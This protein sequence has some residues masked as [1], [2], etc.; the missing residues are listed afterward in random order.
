MLLT[1][2]STTQDAT[3]LGYLLHKHPGKVQAF[4]V[5]GG[6]AQVFYPEA[7]AE[8]CTAVLLLDVDP[9]ALVRGRKGKW[10]GGG[11][12]G[13]TLDHYVNDR[14]YAASSML[15]VAMGRVFNTALAGRCESRPHLTEA[16]LELELWLPCIA[17]RGG[18]ESLLR[19]LFEPLG[20][21]VAVHRHPLDPNFPE[22]DDGPYYD[23]RLTANIALKD[24]LNHL[25][26]LI[27]VLDNDKHYYVGRDEMEKLLRKGETWLASHPQRE[28]ITARYLRYWGPLTR[29]AVA[30][31]T[32]D[33]PEPDPDAEAA[34]RDAE[35]EAIEERVSLNDQRH[36]AVVEALLASGAK[37][38]LDLGCA[39]GKLIARLL[40]EKQLDEVVGVDVSL[41]SLEVAEKR[42]RLDRMGET[43]RRRVRLL[44]GSLL[45]RDR[46]LE[47]FDAAAL[48]EVIEHLD[49]PRLAAME[50][51]IFGHARPRTVVVTTPNVEYNVLFETLPAGNLRHRDHRFEWSRE[52][53]QQWCEG[54]AERY[55]YRVRLAPVGPVD[56][57][58]GGLGS[59]TQMGVFER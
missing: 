56:D 54:I 17:A 42:L 38:V 31:L 27:P 26:V 55:G 12:E 51:N 32:D 53:F 10:S 36:A 11:G 4:D 34:E 59:P 58:V 25:Y 18:G 45:Y 43:Q 6:V 46:R 2:T 5:A 57:R 19:S 52:E 35:E 44:H 39:Q 16:P 48:V 1:I 29:E 37:R 8:R 28:P 7:T 47:G 40:K 30:R 23:L 3:D 14:P 21:T 50:R 15:S 9:I 13:G 33:T 41:R 49:P 22:W 24:A 20:Y